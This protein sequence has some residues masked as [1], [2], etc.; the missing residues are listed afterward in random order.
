MVYGKEWGKY[1][2]NTLHEVYKELIKYYNQ[3]TVRV[4]SLIKSNEYI[5]QFLPSRIKQTPP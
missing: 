1:Y 2:Q 5:K 4:L 3:I